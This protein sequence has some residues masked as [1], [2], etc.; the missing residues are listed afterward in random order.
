MSIDSKNYVDGL[1]REK[2]FIEITDDFLLNTS[3]NKLLIQIDFLLDV[4]KRY[5]GSVCTRI[6][7]NIE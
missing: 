4:K 5:G 3:N 1:K 2:E 7:Q 6:F